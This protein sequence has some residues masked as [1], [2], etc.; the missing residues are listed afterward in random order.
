MAK[1]GFRNWINGLILSFRLSTSEVNNKKYSSRQ[2]N[3]SYDERD[4]VR[5]IEASLALANKHYNDG[6]LKKCE[7]SLN[8]ARSEVE[9]LRSMDKRPYAV[10][11]LAL[12][13]KLQA[14]DILSKNTRTYNK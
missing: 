7:S 6:N 3:T 13:R 11:I 2:E 1:S 14:R 8:T 9:E 5:R 4:I 12:N 10:R